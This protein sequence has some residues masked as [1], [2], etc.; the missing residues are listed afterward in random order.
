MDITGTKNKIQRLSKI[1]E[2]SYQKI[3]EMLERTQDLQEDVETTSERVERIEEE[4]TRQ[5]AVL[6]AIAEQQ[7]IDPEEVAVT[8]EDGTEETDEATAAATSRPS[9]DG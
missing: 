6:D 2:R 3:N 8:P 7:G 5:R 9:T 4:L 1:V